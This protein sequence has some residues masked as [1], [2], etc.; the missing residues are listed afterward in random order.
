MFV[1]HEMKSGNEMYL[2]LGR[3]SSDYQKNKES[4]GIFSVQKFYIDQNYWA[5]QI[6]DA[7]GADVNRRWFVDGWRPSTVQ[8]KV[9]NQKDTYRMVL[10]FRGEL[11]SGWD[12]D[13]GIVISKATM[14]DT[15][16][17]RISAIE[18]VAGLN[19]VSY[20][21]LTLPTMMSV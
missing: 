11:D 19:A 2:E 10:G 12:W 9:D 16:A 21:H 1:N 5:Q 20:T 6:E 8:R 4:G 18:F 7:T 14:E 17:N 3:Y 15:T 13:T